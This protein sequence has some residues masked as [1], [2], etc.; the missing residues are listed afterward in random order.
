MKYSPE[1]AYQ[2]KKEKSNA[3]NNSTAWYLKRK[4]KQLSK[5]LRA[6]QQPDRH[7][8]VMDDEMFE[9]IK[10][11]LES[12]DIEDKKLAREIILKSKLT[13]GQISYFINNYCDELLNGFVKAEWW[14][15]MD[16]TSYLTHTYTYQ[17]GSYIITK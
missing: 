2:A 14:N 4:R 12:T 9:S 1:F 7:V 13:P 11:M 5:R 10:S 3:Y 17:S 16:F 8:H 6:L 15:T